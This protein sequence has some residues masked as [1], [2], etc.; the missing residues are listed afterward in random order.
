MAR[1]VRNEACP[2][3]RSRG[4]DSRG[5][6]L[7]CYSDDSRHCFACGFHVHRS[8]SNFW[9]NGG[10]FVNEAIHPSVKKI[11]PHDFTRDIP[12]S[13]LKWL[14]QYGL[15]WSY[16]KETIGYS[17]SEERLVFLVGTPTQFSI[18]RYVQSNLA[19][20]SGESSSV[21]KARMPRK[22][23]VWGD[24]HKHCEALG[25]G[26]TICLVE[27]LISAHKIATSVPAVAVPLFGVNVHPPVLYYIRQA[28]KPVV[29]WL[30]KDQQGSIMKKANQ[31]SVL[32]GVPVRCV[33]TDQDPKCLTKEQINESLYL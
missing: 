4:L 2:Q 30:D 3:C 25:S 33:T 9:A 18:G 32:T 26:E 1:V 23:Y 17:P 11:L 29:L 21:D 13:A 27:D 10:T 16:W 24:C 22:W 5:D 12:N 7:V 19:L 6:N 14:L 31:V 20:P 28:G 15:P 8:T